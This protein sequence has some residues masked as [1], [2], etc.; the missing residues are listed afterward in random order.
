MPIQIVEQVGPS[1]PVGL[2]FLGGSSDRNLVS[3]NNVTTDHDDYLPYD[4][5]YDT[6]DDSSNLDF[7]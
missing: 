5:S 7:Y 6:T 2:P 4:G 1:S 3:S